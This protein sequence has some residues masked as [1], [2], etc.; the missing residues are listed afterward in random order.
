MISRNHNTNPVIDVRSRWYSIG[1]YDW[2]EIW[3]GYDSKS[4][5]GFA[6][7]RYNSEPQR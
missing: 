1:N 2:G 4:A 3:A 6:G 5:S 7:I